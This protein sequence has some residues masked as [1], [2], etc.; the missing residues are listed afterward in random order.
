MADI[1][2]PDF[3]SPL[4]EGERRN[5]LRRLDDLLLALEELNLK[6]NGELPSGFVSKLLVEGIP[7]RPTS[8]ATDLLEMVLLCQEQYMLKERRAGRRRRR[9]SFIP[10]DEDIVWGLTARMGA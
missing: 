1:R 5:R 7:I 3:Y 10:S 4:D 9:L 2:D 6:S 8:T